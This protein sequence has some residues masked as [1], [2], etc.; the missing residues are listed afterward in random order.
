MARSTFKTFLMKKGTSGYEKLVDIKDY[1]DLGGAPEMLD[2]TTLSDP[3]TTSIPGIQQLEALQ[4]NLN[5]TQDD[6]DTLL[7]L[8]DKEEEYAVFFG[9]TEEADGKITP[10]GDEGKFGFK[11]R[12]SVYVTGGGVNE[13]TGMVATIAPSTAITKITT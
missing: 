3:M 11:G 13:V 8:K 1:P 12:L 4:F 10:T 7:A 9:G 6:Y 2:T 5:Y